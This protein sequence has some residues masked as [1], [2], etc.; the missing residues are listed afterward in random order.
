[1][2]GR[3][4]VKDQAG[5]GQ[6]LHMIVEVDACGVC[7]TAFNDH[8]QPLGAVMLDYFGNRLSAVIAGGWDEE[9]SDIYVLVDDVDSSRITDLRDTTAEC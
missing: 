9:P 7:V 2:T 8:D 6:P 3:T 4:I 5:A 1:M